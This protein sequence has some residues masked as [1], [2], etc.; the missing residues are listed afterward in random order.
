M[1]MIRTYAFLLAEGKLNIPF[2]TMNVMM[3]IDKGDRETEFL[4]VLSTTHFDL[5]PLPLNDFFVRIGSNLRSFYD[6]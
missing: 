6:P 5:E 1:N 2:Q 4:C 3:L